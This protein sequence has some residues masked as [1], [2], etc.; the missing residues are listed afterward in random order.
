M[1]EKQRKTLRLVC[2]IVLSVLTVTAGVLLIVQAERVYHSPGGYSREIV[3]K[4]LSEISAVLYVWIAFVVINAVVWCVFPPE[5]AR[6]KATIYHTDTLKRLKPRVS[7]LES[8][9]LRRAETVKNI[10][11]GVATAFIILATVMVSLVVFNK[12]YYHFGA[13][14]FNPMRD[15]LTMLPEFMPWVV[16]SF[17]VAIIVTVYFEISAK[18]EVKEIKRILAESAKNPDGGTANKN[19][20]PSVLDKIKEK[21]DKIIPDALKTKRARRYA[22]LGTRLS[23]TVLSV[24][25]IVVGILNGGIVSVLEKAIAICRECIGLG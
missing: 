19:V 10:V 17:V 12:D 25:F 20:K 2:S 3:G 8:E 21:I 23:L 24:V 5:P 4:Y 13:S 9:K 18:H 22:L 14:E 7:G 6:L 1:T 11:V 15:M 16:A